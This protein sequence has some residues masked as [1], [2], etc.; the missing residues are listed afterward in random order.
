MPLGRP[1]GKLDVTWYPNWESYYHSMPKRKRDPVG[2]LRRY[3]RRKNNAARRRPIRRRRARYVK[4]MRRLTGTSG[5]PN[6]RVSRCY[7][8]T[9]LQLKEDTEY[10]HGAAGVQKGFWRPTLGTPTE[11]YVTLQNVPGYGT[12]AGMFRY[13]KINAVIVEY[14]PMSRSDQYINQFAWALGDTGADA[15]WYQSKAGSLELKS[16]R[17]TGSESLPSS[18]SEC[19]NRAG[20]LRKMPTTRPVRI[21]SFPVI[22]NEMSDDAAGVDPFKVIRSPWLSTEIPNHETLKHYINFYCFHTVNNLSF[23][24]AQPMYMQRRVVIDVSFKG[25][26]L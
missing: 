10:L 2:A 5:M 13:F 20:T 12:F 17:Y 8:D 26:K 24:D 1:Q 23:D 4:P 14:T 3:V 11:G 15:K 19:L 7:D 18:W 9:P 6:M 22:H 21:K 25:N 16:I